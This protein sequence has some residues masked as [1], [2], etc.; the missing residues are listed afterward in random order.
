MGTPDSHPD[1]KPDEGP[2]HEVNINGFW[3]SEH[4]ITWEQYEAFV[5]RE[6][7]NSDFVDEDKLNEL[8]IDGVSSATQPY[9]EMSFGM[10]KEGYPAVNMTQYAA[11]MYCKWLTAET[12]IFYRLPTEA[13]WE[14]A[15]KLG[16]P[17]NGKAG[18]IDDYAVYNLNSG[19]KYAKI[20]T[21]KPNLLGIYDLQGNVAEWTMDQYIENYFDISPRDNPWNVPTTLYPRVVKGGSWKQGKEDLRC[22]ARQPSSPMWKRRDPQLPKSRWWLTNASFVGFRIV[23]PAVQPPKDEIEKYWLEPVEDFGN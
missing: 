18:D 1:F 7:T 13:E 6:S 21:K 3:M 19:D 10:G 4:E 11:L 20:K 23:R 14:Y 8:G 22:S 12:G 2:L 15:C 17:L 5:F 16:D 9:V